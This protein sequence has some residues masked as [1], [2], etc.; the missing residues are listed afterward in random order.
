MREDGRVEADDQ[1]FAEYLRRRLTQPVT[2]F[3]SGTL[4][5]LDGGGRDALELRPGDGRYVVASVRSM[6]AEEEGVQIL[7][8]VW[9]R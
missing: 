8:I 2:V 1:A 9:D 4:G 7:R 5:R 3:R 6:A